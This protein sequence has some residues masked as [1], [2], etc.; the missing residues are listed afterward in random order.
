MDDLLDLFDRD[1]KPGSRARRSPGGLR[2]LVQ[3]LTHQGDDH[4]DRRDRDHDDNDDLPRSHD[5]Q[6][7]R[8]DDHDPFDL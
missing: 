8:H 3:R 2:G 1:R 6:R 5:R 7:R 4:P